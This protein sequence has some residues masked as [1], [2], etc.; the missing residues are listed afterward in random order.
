MVKLSLLNIEQTYF[1]HAMRRL[2]AL[3]FIGVM[4]LVFVA[5]SVSGAQG[6][7][8]N[9]TCGE[10]PGRE[11]LEELQH[12][13]R[14]M[15]GLRDLNELTA[16][17]RDH[18][19]P[20]DALE[21]ALDEPGTGRMLREVLDL[22]DKLTAELRLAP[23]W[24]KGTSEK[25]KLA[26]QIAAGADLPTRFARAVATRGTS[27]ASDKLRDLSNILKDMRILLAVVVQ[28]N[29]VIGAYLAI[30]ERVVSS[31]AADAQVIAAATERTNSAIE[32]AGNAL[33][34][35]N[36]DAVQPE[37]PLDAVINAAETRIRAIQEACNE[38]A[39][40]KAARDEE[41]CLTRSGLNRSQVSS[42]RREMSKLELSSWEIES[43]IARIDSKPAGLEYLI[44]NINEALPMLVA[45]SRTGGEGA[46]EALREVDRANAQKRAY[47]SELNELNRR[48]PTLVPQLLE[49]LAKFRQ[50]HSERSRVVSQFD[51]CITAQSETSP[52]RGE[53]VAPSTACT[54]AARV[55]SAVPAQ[56]TDAFKSR[57]ERKL[58][59]APNPNGQV[60]YHMAPA[61]T[62]TFS[63]GQG[64]KFLLAGNERG[65]ASWSVDNF[66]FV[67]IERSTGTRR[68]IIGSSDPVF[69]MGTA[70]SNLGNG[71]SSGPFDITPFVPG[72]GT[73]TVRIWA[74]DYGV[75][76]HVSD[77]FLI[78]DS[79]SE[80]R[81]APA[82]VISSY[83][84]NFQNVVGTEWS[85]NST[86]VTPSGARKFLGQFG[87][88]KISLTLN[89]LA[90]HTSVAVS[91]D[92]Y[93][94][95]SWDGNGTQYGPDFWDFSVDDQPALLH[96]TF[97]NVTPGGPYP[98]GVKVSEVNSLG[99]KYYGDSV[100][101]L[102]YTIPHSGRTI[103]LNFSASGLQGLD[104][105]S[106]GLDNVK[107]TVR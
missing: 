10:A 42:L 71:F 39:R 99:Y 9:V 60:A 94:I 34:K 66:I 97:G 83:E 98:A 51:D 48:A 63:L 12:L 64:R 17:L 70:L 93:V 43:A 45:R 2:S 53:S 33:G 54:R 81:E 96:T 58:T 75:R 107:V 32:E 38:Q 77:L 76:G 84:N 16:A 78:S 89:N 3:M 7:A 29:P 14:I 19:R 91:F 61:F 36:P 59:F 4:A 15:T 46:L 23:K 100:Y 104:D 79:C 68:F 65:T 69:Y 1:V 67:E 40:I 5:L 50:A 18:V 21:K 106:W 82:N 92:L 55:F 49:K 72:A 27:S 13:Q 20:T 86:D 103:K 90:P 8:V 26:Q 31:I 73:A 101:R 28:V 95:Q 41:T 74:V 85:K 44:A 52:E 102:T 80:P 57:I 30:T 35:L 56:A 22:G 24:L 87:N 25:A 62:T 47:Q 11:E 88:E 6:Q 37:N 105:E